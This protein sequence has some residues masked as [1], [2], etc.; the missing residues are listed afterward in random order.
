MAEHLEVRRGWCGPCHRR[1]GLLVHF[2]GNKA[3]KIEG[4]PEHPVNRGAM[5][6]RG[7][8]ILEHLYHPD[9]LN[10]PLKR[11]DGKGQGRW[12]RITWDQALDEIARKLMVIKDEAGPEAL[13]FSSGTYRTYGWARKR[14]YN[15]FGS[16][17][18]TG[19]SQI[20][21][22]PSHTIEW[23]TYGFFARGDVRNANL[24]VVW[25]FQPSNSYPIPD[26]IDLVRAKKSGTKLIVIDPRRTNLASK[27]DHWV[28]LRPGTDD[29]LAL[30]MLHVIIKEGLYD[31]D[32]VSK[33]TVGFDEL[34]ERVESYTPERVAEITWVPA[35]TIREVA[36]TYA[37]T[38]PAC[39]QWGVALDQ[40]INSFQTI[41][42]V[43][44]LSGIT[45]NIDV[46]GGDD[47]LVA[48]PF[49]QV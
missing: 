2:D 33:W 36:R 25:G 15:L 22:C 11:S 18:V 45:G 9:R 1:C 7:R 14:F 49:D 12:Q 46:P 24:V 16:P 48:V 4:D 35:D 39:I 41:R 37:T 32:F 6:E 21:M 34:A 10:Y 38:R 43:L 26:W 44:L 8:L 23:S 5:C 42:A 17:N 19:G 27:A 31:K 3:I 40:N 28:Q 29:A 30:G 20:C 13:A 47:A